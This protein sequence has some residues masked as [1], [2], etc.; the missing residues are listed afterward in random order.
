MKILVNTA[1]PSGTTLTP[2]AKLVSLTSANDVAVAWSTTCELLGEL[3][4]GPRCPL[5]AIIGRLAGKV[6]RVHTLDAEL[7]ALQARVTKL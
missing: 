2:A 7:A 1:S 6:A 3:V 4:E 5:A